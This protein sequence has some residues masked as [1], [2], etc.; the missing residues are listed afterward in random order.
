MLPPRRL[1]DLPKNQ[2]MHETSV[3]DG[4]PFQSIVVQPYYPSQLPEQIS[5]VNR[6]N[7]PI[8]CGNNCRVQI[9]RASILV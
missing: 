9:S 6:G 4:Q 5:K 3:P 1:L 8:H 2:S 7:E